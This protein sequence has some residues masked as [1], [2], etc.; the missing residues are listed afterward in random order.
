MDDL[1]SESE[2]AEIEQRLAQ[3]LVAAPPWVAFLET[4]S[5]TGGE[6]FVDNEM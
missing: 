4:R 5:G 3:V 6:S 1:L 2:L